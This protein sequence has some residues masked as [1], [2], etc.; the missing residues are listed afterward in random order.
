MFLHILQQEFFILNLH[1]FS[2]GPQIVS[3]QEAHHK[4]RSVRSAY[5][6]GQCQELRCTIHFNEILFTIE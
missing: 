3:N 1:E 5:R 4:Q 6:V 2:Q